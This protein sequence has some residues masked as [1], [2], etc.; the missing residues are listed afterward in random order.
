MRS[1]YRTTAV[2]ALAAALFSTGCGHRAPQEPP[3]SAP[4]QKSDMPL[5]E[6]AP[7]N[8][9]PEFLR[10]A[11]VL[12]PLPQENLARLA[13]RH[14]EVAAHM[15]HYNRV[16]VPTY[17]LFGT[18]TDQQVQQ[19]RSTH[20]VRIPTRSLTES[21]RLALSTWFETWRKEMKG[22]EITSDFLV[23][24]YRYGA[25]QDL[26]N[27]DIG[28][29]IQGNHYVHIKFWVRLGGGKVETITNS[30]AFI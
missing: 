24:L 8:P 1:A 3:V 17:E 30:V 29:E 28:F 4:A 15:T 23:E 27:L 16:L 12:K 20:E 25:K 19:F 22:E 13:S 9:S 26:S 11:R 6:W 5:P 14:P 18:L 2:L 7:K 21:Q 10:A